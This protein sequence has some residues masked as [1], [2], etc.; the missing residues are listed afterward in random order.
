MNTQMRALTKGAGAI[1]ALGVIAVSS[2]GTAQGAP[3]APATVPMP[4]EATYIADTAEDNVAPMTMA[5]TVEGDMVT[6]YATNGSDE[7]AW[8]FGTQKDGEVDMT[9]AYADHIQ[10]SYDGSQLRGT[11]T[12][13]D[14]SKPHTFAARS[15]AAPAGIYTATMGPERA[16]WV[17][18]ANRTMTGVM[19]NSAPGDHKVTDQLAAAD[20]QFKD[21]VRQM[22]LAQQMQQAPHMEYGTW[23]TVIDN[24]PVTATRVTG[25]TRFWRHPQW[26]GPGRLASRL[27]PYRRC[28]QAAR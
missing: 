9:S 11:L 22:R 8:F 4:P 13:N 28:T 19:D 20:Q 5:V 25:S 15:A 14:G 23:S 24:T 21:Q 1:V 16:T 18:R 12:M 7:Q 2:G 10:G 17:V 6:A 27:G 3:A 26:R